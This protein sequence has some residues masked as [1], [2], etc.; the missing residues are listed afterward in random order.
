MIQVEIDPELLAR[1][2]RHRDRG[3][4]SELVEHALD[5]FL[6]YEA[7]QRLSDPGGSTPDMIDIPRRR[8]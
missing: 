5:R 8:Q 2:R 4:D 7:A 6:R 3:T 1:L